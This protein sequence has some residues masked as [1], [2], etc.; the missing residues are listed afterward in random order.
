MQNAIRQAIMPVRSV[1]SSLNN[2]SFVLYFYFPFP[3]SIAIMM[4]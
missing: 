1:W 4:V 3:T 2:K